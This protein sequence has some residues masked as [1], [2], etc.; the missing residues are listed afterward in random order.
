ML[1]RN[2]AVPEKQVIVLSCQPS[3]PPRAP[4]SRRGGAGVPR[5]AAP[6]VGGLVA[7]LSPGAARAETCA[8]TT[9]EADASLPDAWRGQLELLAERTRRTG[10]P[11]ACHGGR[12]RLEPVAGST[13]RRLV[14]TDAEGREKSQEVEAAEDIVP[15]GQ[16]LLAQPL[17]A[18]PG[19]VEAAADPAAAP[20][21]A[22]NDDAKHGA[23]DAA[24]AAKPAHATPPDAGVATTDDATRTSGDRFAFGASLGPRI[25]LPQDDLAVAARLH[26]LGAV[27]ALIIGGWARVEGPSWTLD[28]TS[29]EVSTIAVGPALGARV[30]LGG[31]QLR[32]TLEPALAVVIDRAGVK[33]PEVDSRIGLGAD[34][35]F[36]ISSH[37]R[38]V[39]GVDGEI[40]PA[41]LDGGE[42]RGD[43]DRDGRGA[44]D[45]DMPAGGVGL[46]FGIEAAP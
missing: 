31:P 28:A 20:E 2:D 14:V 35:V 27:G 23:D 43:R 22:V 3:V 11:W 32:F 13:S 36:S 29:T 24:A 10:A 38:F 40:A 16:A 37:V 44:N 26:A 8:P 46:R 7:S 34:A 41:R 18:E 19:E 42:G 6:V 15:F 45:P 1:R 39:V 17:V 5:L 9:V 33:Q 30:L 4:R 12:V 21:A 25:T